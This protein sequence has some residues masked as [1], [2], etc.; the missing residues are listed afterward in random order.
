MLWLSPMPAAFSAG[1]GAGYFGVVNFSE[2]R[3][4]RGLLNLFVAKRSQDH[5]PAFSK[6]LHGG[7][8][9]LRLAHAPPEG[10]PQLL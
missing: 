1:R 4:V 9:V 8:S 3:G 2:Y 6:I 7:I 5:W 10:G